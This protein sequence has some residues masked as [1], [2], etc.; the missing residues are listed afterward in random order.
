MGAASR[1]GL[2]ARDGEAR[3]HHCLDLLADSSSSAAASASANR[4]RRDTRRILALAARTCA[5]AT[6]PRNRMTNSS[7]G[8]LMRTF[9][10]GRRI[11]E[12]QTCTPKTDKSTT[13]AGL[14]S[15]CIST[16]DAPDSAR[17]RRVPC[18]SSVRRRLRNAASRVAHAVRGGRRRRPR[19]PPRVDCS[20]VT[21]R[22]A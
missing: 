16:P 9:W 21:T 8:R 4:L 19:R 11:V 14:P 2:G 1:R 3:G 13:I 6:A 10:F 7:F 22:R 15:S 5:H 20:V 17:A 18:Q 12:R